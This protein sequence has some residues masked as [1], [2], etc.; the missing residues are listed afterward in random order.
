MA[1]DR[2]DKWVNLRALLDSGSTVI[3]MTT[4]AAQRLGL[5]TKRTAATYTWIARRRMP[6]HSA[7]VTLDLY[8]LC[9][10]QLLTTTALVLK[11]ITYD[12]PSQTIN[13]TELTQL[14][15]VQM[16]DP[17]FH[18][19]GPNDLRIG[20]DLCESIVL[21]NKF[22]LQPKLYARET[23]CDWVLSGSQHSTAS[24]F[25]QT[26]YLLLPTLALSN[27]FTSLLLF[28]HYQLM[29]LLSIGF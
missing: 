25:S 21:S 8:C 24:W 28:I 29:S 16:A 14:A 12:L 7:V 2:H 23:M 4:Q 5:P 17:M 6:R 15:G 11:T 26:T 18:T 19:P 1:R 22:H 20:I 27:H 13:A 10:E 9:K 3:V